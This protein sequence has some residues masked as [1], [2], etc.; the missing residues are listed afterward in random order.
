MI[1]LG[2]SLPE[3]AVRGSGAA[4]NSA[5]VQ[6]FFNRLLTL[7]S[8]ARQTLYAS[9][10]NG[11]VTDGWWALL[12]ALY[13]FAAA[14]SDTSLTNLVQASFKATLDTATGNPTFTTDRGWSGSGAG[15][16]RDV[17]TNFNP[18]T[19]S[20]ANFAQNNAM[21][22]AWQLGTTQENADLVENLA[23][24]SHIEIIPLWSD[25]HTY[26]AVNGNGTEVNPI[27]GLDP[28]GFWLA[29]RTASNAQELNRNGSQVS[30]SSNGSAA[31]T[32]SNLIVGPRANTGA[33]L[34]I[35]A[36]LS[37]AQKTALYSRLQT[38]L[39]AVGAV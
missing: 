19:A 30:T 13:V 24:D 22:C 29:Q 35:G 27:L 12:D 33:A 36:A 2:L 4:G 5:Q 34:G 11:G 31:L 37:N 10:I 23:A 8:A 15:G 21:V 18:S 26:W 16:Q 39:H 17:N 3:I 32:N 14:D 28:S 20:G 25:T 1:G 38:Y 7:P 9:L 6:Q